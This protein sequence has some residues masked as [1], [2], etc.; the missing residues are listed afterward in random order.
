MKKQKENQ[1]QTKSVGSN[2]LIVILILITLATSAFG[3]FA[4]ARYQTSVQG[5]GTAQV[6]R[7][8][9]KVTGDK[10]QTQQILLI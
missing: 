6:A 10:T 9:F 8:N 2:F 3:I 1:A 7:W 4:W 5:E